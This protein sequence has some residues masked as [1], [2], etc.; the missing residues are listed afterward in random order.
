[1]V[2]C[3]AVAIRESPAYIG[4]MNLELTD[5]ETGLLERELRQ[6]LDNDRYFLSPRCRALPRDSGQDPTQTGTRAPTRTPAL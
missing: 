1:M 5:E 2:R 3:Q 4:G 6:I